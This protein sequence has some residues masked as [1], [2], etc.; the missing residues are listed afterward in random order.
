MI[1]ITVINCDDVEVQ[2]KWNSKREFVEDI[3]SNNDNIPMLDDV[4]KAVDTDDNEVCTWWRDSNGI[5]VNDLYEEC[6]RKLA[7]D[8]SIFHKTKVKGGKQYAKS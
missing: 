2:Y 3:D 5:I 1:E 7:M 8:K 4:L 6:K